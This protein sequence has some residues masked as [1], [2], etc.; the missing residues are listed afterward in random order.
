MRHFV[1]T[2]HSSPEHPFG[3]HLAEYTACIRQSFGA[4]KGGVRRQDAR[5]QLEKLL[6]EAHA[7][8]GTTSRNY[9]GP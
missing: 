1:V 6:P 8:C 9:L 7:Y 2:T 5:A 4:G 3:Q